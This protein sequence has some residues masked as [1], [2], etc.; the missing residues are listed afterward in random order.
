MVQHTALTDRAATVSPFCLL[1]VVIN[2][3]S[4]IWTADGTK[5]T[6]RKYFGL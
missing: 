3:E 5:E 1:F 2:K 4:A 6:V